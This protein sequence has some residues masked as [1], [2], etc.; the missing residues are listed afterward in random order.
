MRTYAEFYAGIVKPSFA[1]PD[2]VFG[3]AW[4]IIYP[5]IAISF[6][7]L[8]YLIYKHEAP[9]KLMYV[10]GL[11]LLLN[12]LFTPIQL[13][14]KPLWPA[15][16]DIMLVVATLLYFEYRI[17]K[18]SKLIFWLMI[19]YVGWGIFATVLQLTVTFTN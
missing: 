17:Y 8:L 16:I 11:N 4:G 13:G 18:Y 9:K 19:P 15:S 5:L 3:L 7:Y 6:F 2:W 14:L 1:P 10:F 12:I